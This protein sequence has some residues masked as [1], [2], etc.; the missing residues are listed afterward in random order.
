M[1]QQPADPNAKLSA[2]MRVKSFVSDEK[3]FGKKLEVFENEVNAFLETIDNVK[4]FLNGRNSYCIDNRIHVLVWFLEKIPEKQVTTP[5]GATTKEVTIN[6][7]PNT[8]EEPKA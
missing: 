1:I 2:F 7:Q 5:F 8:T 3:P 4:R 6:E